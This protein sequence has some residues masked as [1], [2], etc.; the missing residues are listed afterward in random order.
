ML[1]ADKVILAFVRFNSEGV[2]E[3]VTWLKNK[4][5]VR[6]VKEP[7][8]PSPAILKDMASTKYGEVTLN[9]GGTNG[10]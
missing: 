2:C 3:K 1:I 8:S 7:Y 9:S 4:A 6:A 5:G 10:R